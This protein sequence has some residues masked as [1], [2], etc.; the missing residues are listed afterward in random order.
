M[1]CSNPEC[2][3]GWVELDGTAYAEHQHPIPEGATPEQVQAVMDKRAY[4]AAGTTVRPCGDCRPGQLE[5]WANGCF[6]RGHRASKC[7]LCLEAL[8]EKAAE[9]HDRGGNP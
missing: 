7:D 9:H 6:R 2:R 5:R 1:T 4:V 8:G 3:S